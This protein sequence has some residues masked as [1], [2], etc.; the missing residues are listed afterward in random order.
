MLV[1]DQRGTRLTLTADGRL[2]FPVN[3]G[4][5]GGAAP[6]GEV[7]VPAPVLAALPDG[8][9]LRLLQDPA[10][11]SQSSVAAGGSLGG[12]VARPVAPPMD[13]KLTL[14]DLRTSQQQRV[15]DAM[16]ALSVTVSLPVLASVASDPQ[17]GN[18]AWLIEVQEDG[19]FLGYFL[20]SGGFDPATGKLTYQVP[21][22]QLQGTLFLPVMLQPA[23]VASF[24]PLVHIWSSPFKDAVDFG[25]AGPQFTVFP[26]LGPQVGQR[27]LVYDPVTAGVGWIDASGV[28]P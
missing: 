2:L 25:F 1:G 5:G 19:Q 24:D 12:G 13:L 28:G 16:R 15:P 6:L 21:V 4:S 27:I 26:V 3:E 20:L 10:P 22:S 17:Q 8:S 7:Q 14:E 11:V 18:F 9:R 23:S